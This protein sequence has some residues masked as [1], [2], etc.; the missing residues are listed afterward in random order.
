ME[1][2]KDLAL[3]NER[4]MG[5]S[6]GARS[7]LMSTAVAGGVLAIALCAS[8]AHAADPGVLQLVASA[9]ASGHAIEGFAYNAPVVAVPFPGGR[10]TRVG[11]VY[12]EATRHRRGPRIDNFEVCQGQAPVGINDVSPALPDDDQFKQLTVMAIRGALRY[13]EQRSVWMGYNVAARRL[14]YADP[15]GCAQVETTVDTEG[16][17]VSHHVGRMCP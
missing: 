12:Q 5:D 7:L 6:P 14:S 11:V 10:C 8:P 13:G 17:L 9:A 1:V 4:V 2:T 3:A 15:S 16:L